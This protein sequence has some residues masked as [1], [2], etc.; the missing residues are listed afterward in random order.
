MRNNVG[1][2]EVFE[3]NVALAHRYVDDTSPRKVAD[4]QERNGSLETTAGPQQKLQG[5]NRKSNSN[6]SKNDLLEMYNSYEQTN[7]DCQQEQNS[8]LNQITS[9]LVKQS[10][11]QIFNSK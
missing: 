4:G 6:G 7:E 3:V 2:G 9:F 10:L 5:L 1:V 11:S 8:P